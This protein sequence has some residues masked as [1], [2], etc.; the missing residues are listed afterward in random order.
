MEIDFY[1]EFPTKKNLEKL[2]LIKFPSRI[3][4]AAYSAK[5]FEKYSKQ[6][7]RINRK[8]RAAYWPIIKNSYWISPFSNTCDLIGLF[9]ELS[10]SKVH[11]LIN[12][13]PPL[14]SKKLFFKNMFRFK[15]NKNLIKKFLEENK[16]RVTTA[17][18]PPILNIGIRKAL[19]LDYKLNLE[20]G[21]MWYSSAYPE[22][23]NRK[24]RKNLLKI[25]NK[26]RYTLGLGVI[27]QGVFS[28]NL[29]S[30]E[31]LGADINFIKEAGF[32]KVTIFR[33]GGLNKEYMD[34]INSFS[35]LVKKQEK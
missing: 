30:P 14:L 20:K 25:K 4:I 35:L 8:I 13:E 1:E 26:E 31:K 12:L 24:I 33:L 3:F 6:A 10:K 15:K 28:E 17:Q 34:K 22:I 27:A 2:K 21:L 7:R 18:P 11:L 32:R 9:D 19:G 16:A 23:I 29:L 5:E